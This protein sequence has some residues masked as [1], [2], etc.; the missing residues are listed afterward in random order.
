MELDKFP[1]L[2]RWIP[3]KPDPPGH[4]LAPII[5]AKIKRS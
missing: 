4:I 1:I 5:K 2:Q 3:D